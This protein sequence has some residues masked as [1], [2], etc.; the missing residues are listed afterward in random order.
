MSQPRSFLGRALAAAILLGAAAPAFAQAPA[1]AP[2]A[3]TTPASPAA[4]PA[5][6][7]PAAKPADAAKPGLV[8]INSASKDELDALPGIGTARADAIIKGRPY[9]GKDELLSK[10]IIPSNVYQGIKDKV[11]A[12]QKS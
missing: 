8:D 10:K 6:A 4:K 5:A 2:S 7:T 12:R 3:K 11:I 1:P 9:R